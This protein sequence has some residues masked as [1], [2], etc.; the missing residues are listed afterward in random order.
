MQEP[1]GEQE[2]TEKCR[3]EK[4]LFLKTWWMFY[5]SATHIFLDFLEN[6][7]LSYFNDKNAKSFINKTPFRIFISWVNKKKY[8][9]Y[10]VETP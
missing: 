5:W 4:K 2:R 9:T 1:G 8:K 6:N 7:R 3:T 10:S